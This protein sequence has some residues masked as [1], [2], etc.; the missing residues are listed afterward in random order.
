MHKIKK[1]PLNGDLTSRNA[2]EEDET[3]LRGCHARISTKTMERK[4]EDYGKR[5][6]ELGFDEEHLWD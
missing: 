1:E 4:K 6:S 3:Q 5:L 2:N